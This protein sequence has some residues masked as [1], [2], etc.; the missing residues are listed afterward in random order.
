MLNLD[1]FPVLRANQR[2][3]VIPVL[4]VFHVLPGLILQ[5]FGSRNSLRI[6]T[7]QV[8]HFVPPVNIQQLTSR[9]HTVSSINIS[10]VF[11]VIIH[12]PV[13]PVIRPK[14]LQI[15]NISPFH[16][17]DFT[18]HTLL[19]HIQRRQ[20][21][22]IIHAILQHHAMQLFLLCHINQRPNFLHVHGGRHLDRHVLPMFHGIQRHRGMM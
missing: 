10:P 11:P 2:D 5:I 16:V 13:I 20:F 9:S 12:T 21:E 14:F 7:Y 1:G 22:E 3:R 15:M 8:I 4:E 19:C 17:Q 18:K 6:H